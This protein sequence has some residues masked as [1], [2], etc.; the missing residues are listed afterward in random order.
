MSRELSQ[1]IACR[2]C[3]LLQRRQPLQ[4]GQSAHCC[5]C[6][7]LLYR[8]DDG[9]QRALPLLFAS[10]LLL[11]LA[12][13]LPLITLEVGSMAREMHLVSAVVALYTNYNPPLSLFVAMILLILPLMR[14]I[15]LI[16]VLWAAESGW[17]LP[18][19]RRV[20]HLTEEVAPWTM[21]EI[22]LLGVV[23]A[24]VK[25][26]VMGEVILGGA[27]FAFVGFIIAQVWAETLINHEA[28]WRK[29]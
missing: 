27:L 1:L 3:D 4:P 5:R 8:D 14:V 9:H 22:Y 21:H 11:L 29:L 6:H 15:G 18:A 10:L 19:W 23:V 12:S 17:A 24:L 25:L 26:A 2:Y 13:S 7:S 16:Y 28:L 20:W